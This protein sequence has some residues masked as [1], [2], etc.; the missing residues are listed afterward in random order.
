M[1]RP[2]KPTELLKASGGFRADRHGNRL[3]AA[4]VSHDKPYK[5]AWLTGP[6][7]AVYDAIV[8]SLVGSALASSDVW[9]IAGAARWWTVWRKFDGKIKT[10]RGDQYKLVMLATMAWKNFEK[11]AAKLG[12]SPVDRARLQLESG[13]KGEETPQFK[14]KIV[15]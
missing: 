14:S 12:L 3:D 10:G 15:G 1:A 9:L 4:I 2:R 6:A 8:E 7:V 13:P 5:P 11:C